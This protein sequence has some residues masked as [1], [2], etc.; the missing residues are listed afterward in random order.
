M[1]LAISIVLVTLSPITNL[2]AY[3]L[4]LQPRAISKKNVVR[5]GDIARVEGER[6]PGD[7]RDKV[8]VQDLRA[9]L[10]ISRAELEQKLSGGPDRLDRVYGRGVWIVPLTEKL[11]AEKILAVLRANLERMPGG[12]DFLENHR[13]RIDGEARLDGTPDESALHFVLPSRIDLLSP[14]MRM[15]TVDVRGD[16]D[17]RTRV[18][19]RQH[20][21]VRIYRRVKVAVAT[22]ALGVGERLQAGDW[23]EEIR[24]IDYAPARYV[25][26]DLDGRRVMSK[27]PVGSLLTAATVQVMPAVRRGMRVELVHQTPGLVFKIQSVAGRDGKIGDVIPV[28]AVFP[29]GKGKRELNARVVDDG[30]VVLL[31]PTTTK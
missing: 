22:R 8:V 28:T 26:G 18:L 14:G 7:I 19:M 16:E 10:F 29:T 15:I 27:L 12:K 17:G 31:G 20:V 2:F 25:T 30:R 4:Y 1:K 11:S 5:M 3:S 23:R 24:E 9:P 21:P 13:L 6:R